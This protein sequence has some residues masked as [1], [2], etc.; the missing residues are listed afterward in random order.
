[1]KTLLIDCA[2]DTEVYLIRPVDRRVG[3]A[4][5]TL[6]TGRRLALAATGSQ[7]TLHRPVTGARQHARRWKP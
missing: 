5:G 6:N 2:N 7:A 4:S 3:P 1:M